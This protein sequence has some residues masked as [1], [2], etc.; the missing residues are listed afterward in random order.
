MA[1]VDGRPRYVTALGATN[2]AEGWR[3]GKVNGGILMDVATGEVVVRGLSMPHSPRVHGGRLW[4]LEGGTG[5]L[6]LVD[7]ATGKCETV[8]EFP[9]FARGLSIHGSLAFVGLSKIRESALF[10]GLPIASKVNELQCGIW[11]VDLSTGQ[12]VQFMRFES[13]V[14][15]IFAVEVLIGVRFPEV[16]GLQQD[17]LDRTYIIPALTVPS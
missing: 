15:E 9:G 6:Q 3:P 11:V 17:Q 2:T 8:A 4:L 16:F 14:E 5:R 10:G 12:T 13:G 7:A 1:I